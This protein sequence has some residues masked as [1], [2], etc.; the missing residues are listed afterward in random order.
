MPFGFGLGDDCFQITDGCLGQAVLFGG[1]DLFPKS[2]GALFGLVLGWFA[3]HHASH[4]CGGGGQSQGQD[5]RLNGWSAHGASSPR[6]RLLMDI[7]WEY[8]E[9]PF[10]IPFYMQMRG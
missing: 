4:A 10:F 2:G 5:D 9:E 3:F 7:R 6:R 1:F 8:K